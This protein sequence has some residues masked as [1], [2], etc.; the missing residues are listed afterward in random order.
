MA[1][2]MRVDILNIFISPNSM[3]Q[4]SH[5]FLHLIKS[6]LLSSMT[7]CYHDALPT[8][9][10]RLKEKKLN[11][12]IVYCKSMTSHNVRIQT[13]ICNNNRLLWPLRSVLNGVRR[14]S[15]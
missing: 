15:T 8:I 7:R 6:N 3:N 12:G 2:Y 9:Q 4:L 14:I 13:I 1:R 5:L 10:E 11:P